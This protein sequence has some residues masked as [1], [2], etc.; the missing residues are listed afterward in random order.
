MTGDAVLTPPRS[1]PPVPRADIRSVAGMSLV[2]LVLV[3]LPVSIIK[4]IDALV[5]YM[6]PM[7]ALWSCAV[8]V[9]ATAAGALV[10]AALVRVVGWLA[11]RAGLRTRADAFAWWLLLMPCAVFALWQLVAAVRLW[12][13]M[14]FHI[15]PTLTASI[16][17]FALAALMIG[18]WVLAWR[19]E[20]G[21]VIAALLRRTS[22][23]VP[24]ALVAI[25]A[26]LVAAIAHPPR[27]LLPKHM[28]PRAVAQAGA[29]NVILVTIDTLSEDDANVCGDG[30]T[31]MPNLRNFARQS[32][33]FSHLYAAANF[34]VPGTSTIETGTLP[35]T[36]RAVQPG[37]DIDEPARASSFGS[38]LGAAGYNTAVVGDN[39][40]ASPR[41]HGTDA[42]YDVDE[43][44]PSR[45]LASEVAKP[46]SVFDDAALPVLLSPI[47]VVA[48]A[49]DV[50]I[51][52]D[53]APDDPWS[54]YGRGLELLHSAPAQQPQ[55]LWLHT[56]P[57]HAPYL[58]PSSTRHRLLPAGELESWRDFLP[59]NLTYAPALQPL[60][61]KH[62]LRYR[63]SILGADEALGELLTQLERDAR[64]ANSV[65][66]VSSDHGELFSKGYMGHSGD[67]LDEPLLHI[68]LV[69]HM[70][71]QH[72]AKTISTPVSQADLLPTVA[73]IAGA[74]VPVGVE[75]RS[76]VG[77]LD[78]GVLSPRP[79]FSMAMERTSRFKAARRG[80]YAVMDG[81]YKLVHYLDDGRDELYDLAADPLES[82]DLASSRPAD[83]NRLRTLLLSALRDAE[84]RRKTDAM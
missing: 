13:T 10:F 71:G 30:P 59:E 23:A 4:Q 43:L 82:T 46:L 58:P 26:S 54:V 14:V 60:V 45:A 47:G 19:R 83:R 42:A 55:F 22:S 27:A 24:V 69:I 75:G 81:S 5:A 41:H 78:T 37:A 25:L 1:S 51:D 52:G 11:A 65:I 49:L 29:P 20:W 8:A 44:A 32:T 80:T 57:P 73:Q 28:R 70:P 15:E 67:R 38:V 18:S 40:L 33:C 9:L 3:C 36:H 6:T 56:L 72:Q 2:M 16:R 12:L 39:L 34:T 74:P 63:E 84:K 53:R 21:G 68:P 17:I 61:D 31:L 48:H 50:Y 62:R 76:L 7:R 79:V 66:I 35:W 64:F 77:A